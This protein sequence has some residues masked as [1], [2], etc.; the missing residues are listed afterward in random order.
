MKEWIL[1]IVVPILPILQ[2]SVLLLQNRGRLPGSLLQNKLPPNLREDS[3]TA[4]VKLV[5]VPVYPCIA[6]PTHP[7]VGKAVQLSREASLWNLAA[8][9]GSGIVK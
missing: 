7:L 6:A 3:K 2:A 4:A 9:A 8:H 1:R 5:V